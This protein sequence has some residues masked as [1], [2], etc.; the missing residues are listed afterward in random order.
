MLIAFICEDCGAYVNNLKNGEKYCP[1]C[2]KR[3]SKKSEEFNINLNT[4]SGDINKKCKN[5]GLAY[6]SPDEAQQEASKNKAYNKKKTHDKIMTGIKQ[7]INDK[8]IL[9]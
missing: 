8:G 5:E 1:Y 7:E 4:V 2:P 6:I 9:N 3:E